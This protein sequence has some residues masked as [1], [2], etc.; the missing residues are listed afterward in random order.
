M[1][2]APLEDLCGFDP[3]AWD[4]VSA[5][6]R[7][8]TGKWVKATWQVEVAERSWW[9]V[10]GMGIIDDLEP[11]FDQ[12]PDD[13]AEWILQRLGTDEATQRHLGRVLQAATNDHLTESQ[14]T[15]FAAR[16]PTLGTADLQA[17]CHVLNYLDTW[18]LRH[19]GLADAIAEHARE[20]D[21]HAE[22]DNA[23]RAQMHPTH[24]GGWNGESPELNTALARARE[25]AQQAA[26]PY[27][28]AAYEQAAERIQ[29]TINAD[30]QRHEEVSE[31]GWN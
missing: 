12:R 10:I 31:S 4:L 27:L 24:W 9:V 19:P 6:V 11:A 21:C 28:R 30:R 8:D 26:D 15:A 3:A 22:A 13:L 20:L 7:T 16:V 29:A 25:A 1:R 18:P 2:D 23:M 5:E 17:F 14:G